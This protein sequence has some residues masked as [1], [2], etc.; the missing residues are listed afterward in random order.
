MFM[1]ATLLGAGALVA[2]AGAS[3]HGELVYAVTQD[4][5]IVSWDSSDPTNLLSARSIR[6]MDSNEIVQ[7]I[8]FR[9]SN[10]LIYALGSFD[11]LY[12]I[13]PANGQ[14]SQVGGAFSMQLDGSNFGFDVD[15]VNDR[16]RVVSDTNDN[17]MIN[18]DNA[19]FMQVVDLAF[20][21][22]DANDGMDPSAVHLSYSNNFVGATSSTLYGIDTEHDILVTVDDSAGTLHT[23]GNLGQ[24]VTALGGFDISGTSGIA[25]AVVQNADLS[26]STF[27]TLN[28]A[29]GAIT[30]VG[31]VD[32]G[33][34][35][36]AMTVIPA[37]ATGLA[38]GLMPLALRRRRR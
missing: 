24:D 19:D 18:P 3:A 14:V 13:D 20:A 10:G 26:R 33:I 27:V 38:F 23:L 6:G 1:R 31:Q 32:G 29:T 30:E 21:A 37:P 12:T 28:L 22:G 15:P 34:V 17:Y 2:L 25:Y 7:S 11:H 5:K 36:T 9:P 16:I 4:Q 35:I 8:D